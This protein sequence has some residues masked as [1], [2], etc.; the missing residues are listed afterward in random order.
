MPDFDGVFMKKIWKKLLVPALALIFA[1]SGIIGCGGN[2]WDPSKVTLKPSDAGELK[3]TGMAGFIAET[4]NYV[5]MIN[6]I[7]GSAEDNSFGAPVKG[8]LV[9]AKKSDL[10]DACV[11]VPKLFVASDYKAG[12]FIDGDYVYYGTPNTDKDSS[13]NVANSELT[14]ARTKLDGTGF[15]TYFSIPSLSSE[16]R[17]IKSGESVYLVYYDTENSALVSYNTSDK[18]STV[19]AK[20]SDKAT[21]ESLASN[22]YKFVGTADCA[23]V[24]TVDVYEDTFNQA[25]KDALGDSYSRATANYNRVYAYK[26][27]DN[28]E[29]ECKGTVIAN[30]QKAIAEKYALTLVKSGYIFLSSTDTAETTSTVNYAINLSDLASGVDKIVNPTYVS[31]S[32]I[33]VS[34]TEVYAV[35]S[36]RI[37]KLSLTENKSTSLEYVAKASTLGTLLLKDG[38]FIYYTNTDSELARIYIGNPDGKEEKDLM[39]QRVSEGSV[40]TSWYAPEIVDGKIF[41][42]DNSTDGQSYVKYVSTTADL[43]VEKDD[44]DKITL[45]YLK[46]NAFAGVVLGQDKADIVTNQI[47]ALSTTL[48]GSIKFDVDDD[49]NVVLVEGEPKV[50]VITEARAAYDA[51]GD[52][53]KYVS[54]DTL[55]I[56]EKYEEALRISKVFYKLYDFDKVADKDSLR[57]AY[58]NAKSELTALK[59][60]NKYPV[61]EIRSMLAENLNYFYQEAD[62]HFNPTEA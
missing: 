46:G 1:L 19:I 2:G 60:S 8:A 14:F 37:A 58:D 57:T 28:N 50:D 47:N 30:G 38:D 31:D 32:N 10:S 43:E 53:K 49:G 59:N 39:E 24:Y 44:D 61:A 54:E 62:K 26:I 56:L 15:E 9:A 11:V 48:S 3:E 35:E 51:L 18:T 5:Y 40:S 4:A 55:A 23:V 29:G 16:Y 25:E 27:G 45:C 41:Y 7:G 12:L 36:E 22:G 33:I 13:G 42:L 21:S 6:G 20:T 17:F 34:L 52:N